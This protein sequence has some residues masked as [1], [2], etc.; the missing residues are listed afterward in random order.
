MKYKNLSKSFQQY[1]E[2]DA[3]ELADVYDSW[4]TRKQFAYD[5]CYDI[6]AEL[7]GYDFRIVTHN[8]NFFT[9]GF[10]YYVGEEE[11]FI[12]VTHTDVYYCPMSQLEG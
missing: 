2:S 7:D 12:F 8:R 5:E 3:E 4:S 10:I 6:F 1:L 11:R 9:V